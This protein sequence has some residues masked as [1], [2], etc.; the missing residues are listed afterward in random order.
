MALQADHIH[1]RQDAAGAPAAPPHRPAVERAER[2]SR[3]VRILRIALPVCALFIG[4]LYFLSSGHEVS[5]GDINAS[6]SRVE[7]SKDRLRMVDPKMEGVTDDNGNYKVTAE[8]AEQEVGNTKL[9]HLHKVR[10][11]VNNGSRG[12]TRLT[13]PKGLFD[14]KTQALVLTGDIEVTTHSGMT[15]R[16]TRADVDMKAQIITSTEPVTV[17]F[18]DGQLDARAMH[19]AM[20]KREISFLGDVKLVT[21]PKR[22]EKAPEG[23][24]AGGT[25]SKAFDSGKPIEVQAPRLTIYDNQKIAHFSGGVLTSQGG[26]RMN[27]NEL[28]AFYTKEDGAGQAGKPQ[29]EPAATTPSSGKLNRIEAIGD[30]RIATADGRTAAGAVLVYDAATRKLVIDQDVAVGQGPSVLKGSRMI[31]DLATSVTSFPAGKRVQGHFV[32][33]ASDKPKEVASAPKRPQAVDLAGGARLD[34]SSSRGKPLDIE[35]DTLTIHDTKKEAVFDGN[36]VTRQ[37]GMDMRSAALRVSYGGEKTAGNQGGASVSKVRADGSVLITTDK[38][39]YVTSEWALYD[40][41]DRIV[42]IGGNVVLTQQENVIKGERLV[43]DLNTGRSRFEDRGNVATNG[44]VRMLF[45]PKK[46]AMG[47]KA[48]P[49]G[50]LNESR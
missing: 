8:Y 25:F 33:K 22:K 1:H 11:E 36:V 46:D 20:R 7:I 13:S 34:L 29:P 43:I 5:I 19:I 44:R 28:K 45:T 24:A 41:A 14:T 23:E 16:L 12:W 4:A 50:N 38:D 42:T 15:S 3:L 2:H 40:A 18:P 26:S 21:M 48:A 39:Q 31:V 49:A 9:V 27:S 35:A 37:G 10:A 30:V 32:P 17:L 6:V 47:K